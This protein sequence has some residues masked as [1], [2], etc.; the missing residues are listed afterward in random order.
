VLKPVHGVHGQGVRVL[1]F[2][3]GEFHTMEGTRRSV[4]ALLAEL[5]PSPYR[6]WLLQDRLHPHPHLVEL[7]GSTFLQTARVI[8]VLGQDGTVTIPAAWLRI[9][10]G[11][12]IFDNFNFGASGNLVGTIDLPTGR[13]DHVLAPGPPG[14]GMVDASRHPVTGMAFQGFA[15]PFAREMQDT[16]ER[17]AIAFAPLRTIGWDVAITPDGPSLIEGNVTWDP[18]PT[19]RDLR[20]FLPSLE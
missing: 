8:T 1:R 16:V 15:L 18:L 6:N 20:Q 17:A 12:L 10:G 14:R 3:D 4:D 7:S 19:K 5:A 2:A 9:I 11:S 13:L